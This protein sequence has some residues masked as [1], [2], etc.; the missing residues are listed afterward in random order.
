MKV[1]AVKWQDATTFTDWEESST[2]KLSDGVLTEIYAVG[3]LL[4]ESK[5]VVSIGLLVSV[6]GHKL[7]NWVNIPKANVLEMIT[8]AEFS[9]EEQDNDKC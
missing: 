1:V 2:D 9:W 5:K 7:S 3:L 4:A 6:N 8:L